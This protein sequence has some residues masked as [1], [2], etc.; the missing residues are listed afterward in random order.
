MEKN[1]SFIKTIG[2]K[3]FAVIAIAAAI[4]CL[5]ALYVITGVNA[6]I[7][8]DKNIILDNGW[9]VIYNGESYNDVNLNNF[10]L[11]KTMGK[12]DKVVLYTSIPKNFKY[13]TPV[14]KIPTTSSVL[15]VSVNG[16]LV[17]TYGEDR[18]AEN[19]LVGSGWHYI[20]VKKTDAGKNIRIIITSTEDAT[21]SSIDA[22]VLMEY[23]DVFQ[24]MMIKNR[25]PY[26]SAVS[27]ILFGA[28]IM[29]LAGIMMIKRTG[30][31]RL[32]WIGDLSVTVGTWTA[33]NYRLTQLFNIPLPVTT[34]LEYINLVLGALS[35][36]M[37]FK[38]NVYELKDNL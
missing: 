20:P 21:F 18:Y 29:A 19:K 33:C 28:L 10:R 23:S 3:I 16:K 36:A 24:Q 8:N 30:M 32:F 4:F 7:N 9:S 14:I 6:G 27:L 38:D 17:Y 15:K 35:V 22:P 12:G 13:D 5:A 31:A 11:P 25:V 26:V 2:G 37:Y 1:N 34:T